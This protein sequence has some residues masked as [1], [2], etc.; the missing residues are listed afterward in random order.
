[1]SDNAL[2]YPNSMKFPFDEQVAKEVGVEEALMLSHIEYWV[3]KNTA[4]KKNFYN[5]HYW[6]YNTQ[7]AFTIIFP[8]WSRQNIRRIISN[9]EK[10]G[11]LRVGSYNKAGYDKTN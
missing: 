7:E 10:S 5:G 6:T 3:R 8:F 1:V 11:L 9:L 4:N 2:P